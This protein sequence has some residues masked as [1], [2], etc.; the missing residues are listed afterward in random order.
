[1]CVCFQ[2]VMFGMCEILVGN[3]EIFCHLYGVILQYVISLAKK[4]EKRQKLDS[5]GSLPEEIKR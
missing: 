4:S 2:R 3:L 1:M 5:I